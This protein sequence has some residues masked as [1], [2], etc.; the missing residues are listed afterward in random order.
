IT[1]P[2]FLTLLLRP[3]V[4]TLFPYTT[5]FRSTAL[6]ACAGT[7]TGTT[8]DALTYSTQ[9]SH[10]VTWTFDD[11]NGNTITQTQTV[12]VDDTIAPVPTLGRP[13][14]CTA[15]TSTTRVPS[16]AWINACT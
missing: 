16:P 11:G 13:H 7:I 4:T 10:T 1:V 6:D 3:T 2:P 15:V 12:V 9:G 14:T 5:L 8:T